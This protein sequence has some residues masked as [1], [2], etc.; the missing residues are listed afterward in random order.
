MQNLCKIVQH[1]Q[2]GGGAIRKPHARAKA[3]LSCHSI[4][5]TQSHSIFC[6]PQHET[7]DWSQWTCQ[8][9]KS[10]LKDLLRSLEMKMSEME[11]KRVGTLFCTFWGLFSQDSYVADSICFPQEGPN[12]LINEDEFFDAVE[13]ALDRQDKIEEQVWWRSKLDLICTTKMSVSLS[14]TH[15]NKAK[16]TK[17][18]LHTLHT[19]MLPFLIVST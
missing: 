18:Q 2:H 1:L 19:E 4:L 14:A 9:N 10:G 5:C 16:W 15:F 11:W 7:L 13:A 3:L 6:P 8:H 17:A 12:S